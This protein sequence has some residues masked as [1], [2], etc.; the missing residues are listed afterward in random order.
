MDKITEYLN[1]VQDDVTR[2]ELQGLFTRFKFSGDMRYIT[3]AEGTTVPA[4][5]SAGYSPGCLF[6]LSNA[7]LGKCPLWQ[8]IGTA[9]SCLFVPVGSVVGYGFGVAGG[10]VDCT[11]GAT[12][13]VIGQ[14]LI[15]P[16]D[17]VFAGHSVSDDNDQIVAVTATAA[18]NAGLITVTTDP[19]TAHD[20]VWAALRNGCLPAWDVFAAGKHTTVGGNVAEAITVAGVTTSDIAFATCTTSDDTDLISDVACTANTVTVTSSADPLV[21]HVFDYVVLRPRGSFKPS[22]Y[23]A[24]AGNRVAVSGDTTTVAITVTG[25]LA[26]D[27]L[28]LNYSATDD[29][30][31]LVKAVVT[32]DTITLTVSADP[33]TEHA[34]NYAL[35]R[36]Y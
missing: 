6:T 24:Y 7:T 14:D 16:S 34:W 10:P 25:A 19:L 26:T 11:N 1:R 35:L 5:A 17:L 30:D 13:L 29:T 20:Y 9:L 8:N 12:T 33:V 4:S 32:A 22:H 21:A 28:I 36:A 3:W 18:K 31:T 15:V 2:R 23:V 27:V